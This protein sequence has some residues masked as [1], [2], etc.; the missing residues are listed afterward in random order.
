MNNKK[1]DVASRSSLNYDVDIIHPAEVHQILD[2]RAPLKYWRQIKDDVQTI[3]L[4]WS[5][6]SYDSESKNLLFNF[7]LKY[8][9]KQKQKNSF[10]LFI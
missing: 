3:V 10:L 9:I 4:K 7:F 5:S 8:K 2:E 1:E 6:L